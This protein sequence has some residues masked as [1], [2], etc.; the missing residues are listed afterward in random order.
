MFNNHKCKFDDRG[1]CPQCEVDKRKRDYYVD[2]LGPSRI[3][4]AKSLRIPDKI[5]EIGETYE[6]DYSFASELEQVE[7]FKKVLFGSCND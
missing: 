3:A 7:N 5:E 6:L 1:L 4:L 2:I